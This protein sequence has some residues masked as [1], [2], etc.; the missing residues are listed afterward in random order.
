MSE[1]SGTGERPITLR[2]YLFHPG[3][4]A[5]ARLF[6]PALP[7]VA[8]CSV[9]TRRKAEISRVSSVSRACSKKGQIKRSLLRKCWFVWIFFFLG[10]GHNNRFDGGSA[11]GKI[12]LHSLIFMRKE[13]RGAPGEPCPGSAPLLF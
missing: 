4:S 10:V 6:V 5:A 2:I 3:A 9:E 12:K 11:S 13:D 7:L 8:A 1:L